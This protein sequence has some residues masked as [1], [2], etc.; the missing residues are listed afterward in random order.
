MAATIVP[1]AS[2]EERH[3][4][5][6]G[7]V[8]Y[9]VIWRDK[10]QRYTQTFADR[11]AARQWK[12]ILERTNHDT[13]KAERAVLSAASSSPTV[14]EAGVR[15]IAGLTNLTPYTLQVYERQVRLHIAPTLGHLP[16]DQVT[17]DD[18]AEWVMHM[19]DKGLSPKTITNVHGL[20]SSIFATAVLRNWCAANPCAGARLPKV[21]KRDDKKE[22]LSHGEFAL[23]LS[24]VDPHFRPFVMF[25]VGTGL[26][27]SEATA[28]TSADFQDAG[29]GE[30]L[31]TVSKAWKED[32]VKG[33]YVGDPKS[34]AAHRVVQMDA[35][36]A[37]AVAPLVGSARAGDPVFTMK[38][39]GAL[40]TQQ[41][42]RKV[43]LP[44][45]DA[46]QSA[47]LRRSPRPH[48]LRHTF[49]SWQLTSGAVSMD[50]L[51]KIMGHESSKT[52][53]AV[54]YHLMPDSRRQAASAMTDIMG[55]VQ[56][57]VEAG[58]SMPALTS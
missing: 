31:V 48:D 53:Y 52:T 54:Y 40:T 17:R 49:A 12:A 23:L 28:L 8:S 13:A 6:S 7:A 9:R 29:G 24:K 27:F 14:K 19:R 32:R 35:T 50:E 42:R 22:F 56:A 21:S 16:V 55:R 43:W 41:F 3:S 37:H 51:A 25:L 45:V 5:A 20:M 2:I 44:A 34:D 46:A 10:G 36:T 15:H 47:G 18:V 58:T 1:M 26:R 33:R 57:A 30:Y 38:R 4:K 11:D 39:G